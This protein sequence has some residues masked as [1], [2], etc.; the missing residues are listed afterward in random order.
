MKIMFDTG[1]NMVTNSNVKMNKKPLTEYENT[2]SKKPAIY[3]KINLSVRDNREPA[4]I[5]DDMRNQTAADIVS[6][7]SETELNN[8]KNQLSNGMYD[9]NAAQI[10]NRLLFDIM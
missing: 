8:I 6:G 1:I 5:I 7:T 4:E 3:D 2:I 10:T 9:P